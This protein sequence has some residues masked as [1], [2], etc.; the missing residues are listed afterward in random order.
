MDWDT[1]QYIQIIGGVLGGV[2][3]L[4]FFVYLGKYEK[5]KKRDR[6]DKRL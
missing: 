1:T 3:L 4:A 5:S 2:A 6:N